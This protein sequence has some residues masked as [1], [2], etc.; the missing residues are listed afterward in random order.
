MLLIC[1]TTV[2]AQQKEDVIYLMDGGQKKGKVITIGDEIVKFSYTGEELQYELKKSLIDKIVFANGREES[3]KSAGN[4]SSTVNTTALQSSAIQGG[5][6][7]AVIPFEIASNDQGLTTDVMRRE[8][9]QACVDALRSRSL[10]IQMQ[11][12]RTTNATLS[13]AG[14]NLADIANHTPEELAKLLGVDYVVLGVYDIENKGTFSYG[15]GVSSYDDK[16]KDNKT[17]V[18]AL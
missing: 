11:D 10:S 16:K 7:L 2:F 12:S 18:S 3:F 13:K 15:S 17:K 6:R 9:Q 1:I 5:N 4:A 14:I 8:V